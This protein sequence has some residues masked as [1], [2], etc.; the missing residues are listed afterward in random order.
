MDL[1]GGH[2]CDRMAPQSRILDATSWFLRLNGFAHNV[3]R[4]CPFAFKLELL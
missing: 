4:M 3:R 1:L 2:R